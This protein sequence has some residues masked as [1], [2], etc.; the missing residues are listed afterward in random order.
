MRRLRRIVRWLRG[1]LLAA[2]GLGMLAVVILAAILAP[3]LTPYSPQEGFAPLQPPSSAHWLGTND[4]GYDL[5]T[6]LLFGARFSL[7]LGALAAAAAVGVGWALGTLAGYS[8]AAGGVIMRVVDVLLSVPRFAI[9]VL[10][11]SFARPGFWNLLLFFALFGW[12]P[13]A[14]IVYG[15][16]RSERRQEYVLALRAVGVPARK[17]LLRHLAPASLPIAYARYVAEMQHVI[18]G[19]VG[20]AYLG[21]GDPLTRSWGMTLSH[22]SR[23]QALLIS[24]VWRWWALPSGLAIAVT[25]LALV[26]LGL[27]LEPLANPRLRRW[28]P[29]GVGGDLPERRPAEELPKERSV[30]ME[31]GPSASGTTRQAMQPPG[32][33]R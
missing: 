18:M 7:L 14:R 23:Y 29:A 2:T 6:E 20:L 28:A 9:I 27:A 1:N 25:C 24:D 33:P 19:E 3:L 17:V 16:V 26:F 22:A 5:W 21:L 32:T 30:A 10:M 11:A 15:H 12:P 8:D 4:L 13:V 31:R